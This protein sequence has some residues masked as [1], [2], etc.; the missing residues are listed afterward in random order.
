MAED[1]AIRGYY[2][3]IPATVRYDASIP[4]NAKLLYGEITALCNERGY[5]WATNA[6]FA[7]LYSVSKKT[8][9]LWI[10]ALQ[11]QGY[12]Q[13]KLVYKENSKEVEGRHITITEGR[14]KNVGT[15]LRTDGSEQKTPDPPAKNVTGNKQTSNTTNTQPKGCG[16]A[17]NPV[18]DSIAEKRK[19]KKVSDMITMRNMISAFTD[20]D[21][22]IE[23]LKKYFDIRVKKGLEPEQW[24]IILD[25]LKTFAGKDAAMQLEQID[26]AIAGGYMQIVAAWN[27]GKT[28]AQQKTR[29][30]NTAGHEAEAV[31]N[32]SAEERKKFE[33]TLARDEQGN[34]MKF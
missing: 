20:N 19:T 1:N 27:K 3:V 15:A 11:E 2:A 9:S 4:A 34:L 22:V 29:F 13:T 28:A 23:R 16:A 7:E 32:M 33:E 25:D 24:K 10:S 31:V 8:V 12:I 30:D 14:I 26:N 17:R 18:K 6:Y 5:C 21:A